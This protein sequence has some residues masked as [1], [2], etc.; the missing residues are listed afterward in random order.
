MRKNI[1]KRVIFVILFIIVCIVFFYINIRGEY[2]QTIAIDK[3]Y[4]DVFK[5]NMKIKFEIFR[6]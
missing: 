1:K 2:L 5:T 6:N 3:K 4:V